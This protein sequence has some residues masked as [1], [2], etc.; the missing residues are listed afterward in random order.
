[1]LED[2]RVESLRVLHADLGDHVGDDLP[3]LEQKL[4]RFFPPEVFLA[5]AVVGELYILMEFALALRF[6]LQALQPQVLEGLSRLL[7]RVHEYLLREDQQIVYLGEGL[8]IEILGGVED[9]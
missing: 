1:M 3:L 5:L 8:G 2:Q 4:H 9:K 6:D 7:D